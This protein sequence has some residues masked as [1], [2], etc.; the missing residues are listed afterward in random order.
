MCSLAVRIV[1]PGITHASTTTA[2]L[3]RQPWNVPHR[4]CEA[5]NCWRAINRTCLDCSCGRRAG[6]D[7]YIA[8]NRRRGKRF[9]LRG[10][11]WA[12]ATQL[13]HHGTEGKG[14]DPGSNQISLRTGERRIIWYCVVKQGVEH[15]LLT[16]LHLYSLKGAWRRCLS[17]RE[18]C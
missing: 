18:F 8:L 5:S 4:Q 17:G 6:R 2:L 14:L 3:I 16:K 7:P 12:E 1:T 13:Q 11:D 10:T 9:R 15:N